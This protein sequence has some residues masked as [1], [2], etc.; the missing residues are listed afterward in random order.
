MRRRAYKAV[1]GVTSFCLVF[2]YTDALLIGTAAKY[3][4]TR[5]V[6]ELDTQHPIVLRRPSTR[7]GKTWADRHGENVTVGD[8]KHDVEGDKSSCLGS[9]PTMYPVTPNRDWGHLLL[10]SFHAN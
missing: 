4:L 10:E 3:V 8:R 6:L 2:R 5:L 7:S 1:I 9:L